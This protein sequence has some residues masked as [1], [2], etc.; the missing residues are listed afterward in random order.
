[1][2]VISEEYLVVGRIVKPHG[3]LGEVK[4]ILP[5]NIAEIF[6]SFE[7]VII[8]T[9]AGREIMTTTAKRVRATPK[10]YLIAFEAISSIEE[11][12]RLRNTHIYVKK[13]SLPKLG[14]GEYYF[15]QILDSK[16]YDEDGEELGHVVDLIE[17]GSN[18]VAVVRAD[19]GEEKL[20]PLVKEYVVEL[21]LSKRRIVVKKAAVV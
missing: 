20:V 2:K 11:A 8:A 5:K 15:F 17:T 7:E 13:T 1:V 6:T 18:D 9:P 3:L 4:A 16:V 19:D 21:N 10:G 12:E 14:E